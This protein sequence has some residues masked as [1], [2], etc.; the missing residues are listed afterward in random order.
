MRLFVCVRQDNLDLA[1]CRSLIFMMQHVLANV[2][3]SVSP[4]GKDP[5]GCGSHTA[6]DMC[7]A[8][9]APSRRS[10]ADHKPSRQFGP[11]VPCNLAFHANLVP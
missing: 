6:T 4:R 1:S 2:E 9:E 10:E 7:K 5:R 3:E 8:S 11:W